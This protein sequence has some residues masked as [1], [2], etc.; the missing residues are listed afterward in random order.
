[1]TTLDEVL[2]EA[3]PK[4]RA[5]LGL[6]IYGTLG[7]MAAAPPSSA[8]DVSVAGGLQS[9]STATFGNAGVRIPKAIVGIDA[10]LHPVRRVSRAETIGSGE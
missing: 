8:R 4:V 5:R 6:H 7:Q 1:M 9:Q 2:D 10:A 3:S